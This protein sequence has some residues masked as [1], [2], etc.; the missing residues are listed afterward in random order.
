MTGSYGYQKVWRKANAAL[1]P[2]DMRRTVKHGG[3]SIMVP[4]D[5]TL[6]D[7]N[8]RSYRTADIQSLLEREDITRMD[9]TALSPDLNLIEHMWEALGR[10]L[11]A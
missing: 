10:C 5:Q 8:V 7:D 2:K 3:G 4:L 11:L 1:E 9:W 6:M